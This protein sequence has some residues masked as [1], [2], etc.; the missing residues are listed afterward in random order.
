MRTILS[1][2]VVVL[3]ALTCVATASQA[4]A[5]RVP[6]PP[7]NPAPSV[8]APLA[9]AALAPAATPAATTPKAAF[10]EVIDDDAH[11]AYKEGV[12]TSCSVAGV[13]TVSFSTVAAGHRRVIEHLSCSLYVS[14]TGALRYVAF[15]ADS[16]TAPRDW[17]PYTRSAA[18]A[19]QYFI[20]SA[21]LFPFEAGETPLVYAFA[22][23]APIQD[24]TCTATGR[25]IVLP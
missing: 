13:C 24:L 12:F 17:M 16:F 9:R 19:G 14:T 2:A 11:G 10:V 8:R 4:L 6:M 25:D 21:A 23:A 15:L 7:V 1:H 22:D 18:D 5:Q 3:G 20:N